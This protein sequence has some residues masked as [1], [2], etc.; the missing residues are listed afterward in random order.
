MEKT[1]AKVIRE[2]CIARK[3][4]YLPTAGWARQASNN[5]FPA[6]LPR[7]G[8]RCL[9][10]SENATIPGE[11]SPA[12]DHLVPLGIGGADTL[13]NIGPQCGPAGASLDRRY[14]KQKDMVEN[15]LA[16]QVKAGN[17]NLKDAQQGIA[18]DWTQYLDHMSA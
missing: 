7:P 9:L 14:F 12:R 4:R 3:G 8:S 15:Y 17:M 16:A 6:E 13:D 2:F 1:V 5:R 11:L 18:T 10:A